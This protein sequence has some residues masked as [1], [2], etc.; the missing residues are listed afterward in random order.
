MKDKELRRVLNRMGLVNN[1]YE[2]LFG[3]NMVDAFARDELAKV[4]AKHA[5]LEERLEEFLNI[6]LHKSKTKYVKKKS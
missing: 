3:G 5:L 2:A 6:K 1:Q 4:Q